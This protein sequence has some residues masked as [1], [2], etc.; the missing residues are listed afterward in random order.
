MSLEIKKV[1]Q[2]ILLINFSEKNKPNDGSIIVKNENISLKKKFIKETF[3]IID[4]GCGIEEYI[5]FTYNILDLSFATQY[6]KILH[7]EIDDYFYNYLFCNIIKTDDF[8]R[9]NYFLKGRKMDIKY[10]DVEKQSFFDEILNKYEINSTN[11]NEIDNII[12]DINKNK[13]YLLLFIKKLQWNCC[14]DILE[15]LY[16]N[17]QYHHIYDKYKFGLNYYDDLLD[18][19]DYYYDDNDDDNDNNSDNDDDDD[20]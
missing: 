12:G 20:D 17:C 18:S 3:D 7:N 8:Y 11:F 15:F 4:W 13:K 2:L 16:E 9:N 14:I 19:L 1:L 5:Y 6:F 10:F